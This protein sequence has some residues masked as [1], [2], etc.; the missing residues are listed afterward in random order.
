MNVKDQPA[1]EQQLS[2]LRQFGFIPEVPLSKNEASQ[3]I[4]N[5]RVQLEAAANQE[6]A[7]PASQAFHLRMIIENAKRAMA[8]ADADEVEDL[9]AEMDGAVAARRD[10]WVDTC[11]EIIRMRVGT[12][13]VHE[14]YK[15][16]GCRFEAPT[17]DQAQ[18]VLDALDSAMPNWDQEHPELFFQ[19]LELNF[20]ELVRRL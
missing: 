17:A 10:F 15:T 18:E 2:C 20:P 5:F 14:L 3:L 11:R 8:E 6:P 13:E 7:R 12:P 19:T 1:T 9:R 4:H 16:L